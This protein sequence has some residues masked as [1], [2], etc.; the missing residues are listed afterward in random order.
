MLTT[1]QARQIAGAY[2]ANTP[3]GQ[4]F[5]AISQGRRVPQTTAA[6]AVEFELAKDPASAALDALQEWI[7]R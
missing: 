2:A 4:T 7:W 5:R 6:A 1:T 3:E